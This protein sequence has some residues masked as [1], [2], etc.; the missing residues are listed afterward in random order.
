VGI[1]IVIMKK[2]IALVLFVSLF[3]MWS[4]HNDDTAI[5]TI[6][7]PKPA[8][9][10]VVIPDFNADSAYAFVKAQV[11]FGPRIPESEAHSHCATW[12]IKKFKSYKLY[13]SINCTNIKTILS[14]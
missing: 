13:R 6:T 12:L 9:K 14:I 5:K 3:L 8:T 10:Q 11:D 2:H 1:R 4:C 7:K